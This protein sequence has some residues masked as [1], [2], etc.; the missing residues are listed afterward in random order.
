ME[1]IDFQK[2]GGVVEIYALSRTRLQRR[3]SLF[4]ICFA[5][6]LF[7]SFFFSRTIALPLAEQSVPI[8]SGYYN[9]CQISSF[10]PFDL[11]GLYLLILSTHVLRSPGL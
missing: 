11:L 5:L 6:H 1:R 2:Q 7:F 4:L 8:F 10:F 9:I 3:I